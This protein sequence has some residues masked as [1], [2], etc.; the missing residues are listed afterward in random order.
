V[1]ENIVVVGAGAAGLRAAARAKRLLPTASVTVL[2]SAEVISYGACGLPYYVSGDIDSLHP[3]RATAWGTTRD[4]TFFKTV[5]ALNVRTGA[6]VVALDRNTRQLRVRIDGASP[7]EQTLHYDKLVIATGAQPR[8]LAGV[9]IGDP[10]VSFFKTPADASSWRQSLERGEVRSVAILGGGYIGCELAEAFGAM[11]GC[12]THII[13]MQDHI[14]PQVLDPEMASLVERHLRE[15]D[16]ELHMGCRCEALED[17]K[18]QGEVVVQTSGGAITAQ[19]VVCA[20]GFVPNVS[21]AQEAGLRTGPFG[22]LVVDEQLRTSDP[23]VFAAGDCVELQHRVSGKP[24]YVPLGSL[25]N[26]QGRI[27]GDVLAGRQASFGPV[28]GSGAV[29]VFDLNVAC[30]GLSAAAAARAGIEADAVWGSFSDIAHYYPTDKNI[31]CKLLFARDGAAGSGAGGQRRVLGLQAVGPGEVV[32]RVDVLAGLLHQQGTLDDVLALEHAY[33]PPY[34]PALDPLFV[35]GCAAANHIRDGVDCASP[36]ALHESSEFQVLDVRTASEVDNRP[37]AATDALHI[38][39][40]ELRERLGEVPRAKPLLVVCAR[41]A[42][43]AETVRI[44]QQHGHDA[45]SYV[46]GGVLMC[47]E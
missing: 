13:E 29:K 33:A 44:L 40:E 37:L 35:L 7:A 25:A 23:H 15:Q 2:D 42:R 34:A 45:A 12:E 16:V 20:L 1:S 9:K 21:F 22:G 19:K 32:K 18:Q 14:L 46:G 41:G 11:W 36:A 39:L 6:R 8:A 43:S 5:K 3:L 27:L 10:R 24:A 26:R 28:V 4:P 31:F 38:P 30:T 47:M 17:G